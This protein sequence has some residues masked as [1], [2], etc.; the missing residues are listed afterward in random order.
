M[1]ASSS[2]QFDE[3]C[4][5]NFDFMVDLEFVEIIERLG[6]A[7]S[8]RTGM[9]DCGIIL[10]GNVDSQ[11][12]SAL[13]S[14]D[15]Y[16]IAITSTP[17]GHFTLCAMSYS[18]LHHFPWRLFGLCDNEY[19]PVFEP[20]ECPLFSFYPSVFE[21]IQLVESFK[22]KRFKSDSWLAIGKPDAC[23]SI[24]TQSDGNAVGIAYRTDQA[25]EL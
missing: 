16:E 17:I 14:V 25:Y 18:T 24:L 23:C 4:T 20:G 10:T 13:L 15:Q 1:M 22:D 6:G 8:R 7:V 12:L 21:A 11:F 5:H 3:L 19:P 2:P 9:G